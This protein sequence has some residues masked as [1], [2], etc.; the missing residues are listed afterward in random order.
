MA[1][2]MR[3]GCH[4]RSWS[5]SGSH[6]GGR[7]LLQRYVGSRVDVRIQIA[8]EQLHQ[9]LIRIEPASSL[10]TCPEHNDDGGG[11][12]DGDDSKKM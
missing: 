3:G 4:S 8:T 10:K 7:M 2:S 1:R 5:H 11:G 9:Q 6:S 12:G